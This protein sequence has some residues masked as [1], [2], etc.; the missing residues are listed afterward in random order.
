MAGVS[1]NAAVKSLRRCKSPLGVQAVSTLDST[2]QSQS[3][4]CHA[5][6]DLQLLG[7]FRVPNVINILEHHRM[8]EVRLLSL[9]SVHS[10]GDSE[11]HF[12]G[13]TAMSQEP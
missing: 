13:C 9:Q 1:F 12:Q 10:I 6:K 4:A 7:T 3:I 8:P 11:V 5:Q 2:A